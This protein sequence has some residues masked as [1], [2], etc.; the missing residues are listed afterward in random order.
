MRAAFRGAK[1]DTNVSDAAPEDSPLEAS[2]Q[3]TEDVSGVVMQSGQPLAGVEVTDQDSDAT[4]NANVITI[5]NAG[6][7]PVGSS[8]ALSICLRIFQGLLL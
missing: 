1:E 3:P 7:T 4:T 5:G 8:G 6:V 2:E